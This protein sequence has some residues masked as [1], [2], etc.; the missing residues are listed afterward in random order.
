MREIRQSGSE[1]GARFNPSF[2]PLLLAFPWCWNRCRNSS[3]S[4][5]LVAGAIRS[6]AFPVR[7]K[8]IKKGMIYSPAHGDMEFTVPLFNEFML[9]AMPQLD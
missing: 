8:L 1:G 7:A 6:V 2:L 3:R 4:I 9:R 5:R